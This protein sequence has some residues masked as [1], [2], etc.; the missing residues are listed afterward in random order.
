MTYKQA[1]EWMNQLEKSARR[2]EEARKDVDLIVLLRFALQI[3]KDI[4][5]KLW[6]EREADEKRK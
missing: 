5:R 6:N 1:L 2:A 3:A 4:E